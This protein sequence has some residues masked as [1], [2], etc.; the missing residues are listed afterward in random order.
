MSGEKNTN[1]IEL[2]SCPQGGEKCADHLREINTYMEHSRDMFECKDF[3]NCLNMLV[4]AHEISFNMSQGFCVKCADLFRELILKSISNLIAELK[5][6]TTGFF[7]RK[8]YIPIYQYAIET[9][10]LLKEKEQKSK[11]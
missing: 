1:S 10:D 11:L 5:R 7:S 8:K 4:R 3:L 9:Y 2:L 6:L